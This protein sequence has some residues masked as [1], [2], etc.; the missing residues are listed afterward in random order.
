MH[1]INGTILIMN[2]VLKL[3]SCICWNVHWCIFLV[4]EITVTLSCRPD[5]MAFDNFL[6][7][8]AMCNAHTELYFK[9]LRK[10]F[11]VSWNRRTFTVVYELPVFF[12]KTYLLGMLQHVRDEHVRVHV[13][14]SSGC[15][16]IQKCCTVWVM[17][18]FLL[19]AI[20]KHYYS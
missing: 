11:V 10:K 16:Y 7:E 15:L 13:K 8:M 6:S 12:S 19:N 4:P 1:F 18:T 3:W 17:F 14:R 5:P 20:T 9:F 2:Y